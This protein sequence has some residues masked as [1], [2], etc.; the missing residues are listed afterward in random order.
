MLFYWIWKFSIVQ[1]ILEYNGS[2]H[3]LRRWCQELVEYN[4]AVINRSAR[5]MRDV[6]ALSR[7]FGNVITLHVIQ[8]HL[9][10]SRFIFARSLAYSLDH[11]HSSSKPQ[12]VL[13]SC[14]PLSQHAILPQKEEVHN[15]LDIHSGSSA[16]IFIMRLSQLYL[17]PPILFFP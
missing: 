14:T 11:F 5:M 15:S 4:F 17:P 6:D 12:R 3:Q 16:K 10:R 2:S 8:A 7:Q 13:P 9:M 1:D